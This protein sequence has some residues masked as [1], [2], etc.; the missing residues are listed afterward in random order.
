MKPFMLSF[1][2]LILL[3]SGC[4]TV[5]PK[6]YTEF[7]KSSPRSILVLP[8]LN[9][10]TDVLAPYSVLT[11]TTR[12]LAELGY[13][14]FPV[15]LVDQYLKENGLTVPGEMHQAPLQKLHEVFGADAVL[16]LTVEKYGSKYQV[17]SSTTMVHLRAKLVDARTGVVLW[18]GNAKAENAG[19]S[20]LIEAVV[21]QIVSKAFDQAHGVAAMASAQLVAIPQTGLLRGPRHPEQ[22]GSKAP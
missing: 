1:A 21:T 20:G 18:E 14:V 16:Y 5:T 10:S 2:A 12:P 19:Q 4:A 3:L 7:R 13:Y 9:E 8:P 17:I 15:V 22:F 6:D 11:T